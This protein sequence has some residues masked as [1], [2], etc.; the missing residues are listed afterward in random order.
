[1]NAYFLS[2]KY[3]KFIFKGIFIFSRFVGIFWKFLEV[4]MTPK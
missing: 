4:K 2:L 3:L 1:M